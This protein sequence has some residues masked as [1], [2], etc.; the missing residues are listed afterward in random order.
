MAQDYG[1]AQPIIDAFKKPYDE[2]TKYLGDPS[3]KTSQKVDTSWHDQMVKQANESFA[4]AQA[5]ASA[6]PKLGG[7]KKKTKTATKKKAAAKR[8]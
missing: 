4:K 6:D 7:A 1:A 3:E 2:L 8:N 5:K